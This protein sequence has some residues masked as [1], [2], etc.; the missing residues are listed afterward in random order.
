MKGEVALKEPEGTIK[1][2][3]TDGPWSTIKVR[4]DTKRL[5][6]L[7]SAAERVS[8]ADLEHEMA[9]ERWERVKAGNLLP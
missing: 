8:M 9:V 3:P 6:D 2:R 5:L 1:E 7:I 4:S